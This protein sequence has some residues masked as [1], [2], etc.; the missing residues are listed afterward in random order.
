MLFK[1]KYDFLSNFY[2]VPI[3]YDKVIWP[4]AEH[5]YQAAKTNIKEEKEI[6]RQCLTAKDAKKA[7]KKLTIRKD[8]EIAG[9]LF[10]MGQICRQKFLQHPDLQEK[11]DCIKEPIIEENYWHDNF[12]GACICEKCKNQEKH[13]WLGHI[14]TDL[15]NYRLDIYIRLLICGSRNFN[16]YELLREKIN[17]IISKIILKKNIVIVSGGANGADSLGEKYAKE[18]GFELKI[19]PADW[20]K[21]GK[22]AGHIRNKQMANF[23]THCI[24]FWD[25]ESPGT[26]NMLE[27]CQQYKII[28]KL[29][30]YKKYE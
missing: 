21:N 11:L 23:V 22:A 2:E 16:N 29:V 12:W 17:L 26:K 7:G 30:Y 5:A 14:L 1:D 18:N 19:Y 28:T 10:D 4:T 27:L 20:E 25:G 6:I 3:L 9:K 24:A 13:N 8:W 15:Q